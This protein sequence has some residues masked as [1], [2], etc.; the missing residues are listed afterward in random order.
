MI[1]KQLHILSAAIV[2]LFFLS[3]LSGA[4]MTSDPLPLH[5]HGPPK[6]KRIHGDFDLAIPHAHSPWD[7][8]FGRGHP[9]AL[10]NREMGTYHSSRRLERKKYE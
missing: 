4:S 2:F 10:L 5:A 7:L 6:A 3:H 9:R 8:W 1:K